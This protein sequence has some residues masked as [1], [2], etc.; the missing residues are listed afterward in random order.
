MAIITSRPALDQLNNQ[1]QSMNS[2]T[3]YMLALDTLTLAYYGTQILC[4]TIYLWNSMETTW[5]YQCSSNYS[6]LHFTINYQE[7]KYATLMHSINVN[8]ITILFGILLSTKI[9]CVSDQFQCT[10]L[11]TISTLPYLITT[12]HVI[13]M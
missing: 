4:F 3:L 5:M 9:V 1:G 2:T 12:K 13:S 7:R 8:V 10:K 6:I 11:L